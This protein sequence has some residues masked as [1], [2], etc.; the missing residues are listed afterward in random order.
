MEPQNVFL[1][2]RGGAQHVAIIYIKKQV[3]VL[4]LSE[5]GADLHAHTLQET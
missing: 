3:Q 2:L 4:P 1:Y 5:R